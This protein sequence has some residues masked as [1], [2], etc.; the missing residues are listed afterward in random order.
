MAG[1]RDQLDERFDGETLDTDVWFPWYLPHWGSRAG[2]AATWSLDGEG[3]HLRIPADQPTWNPDLHDEPLRVSCLQTG[4]FAGPES[5]TR[6]GCPA[7]M[8]RGSKR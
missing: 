8:R 3:L 5:S 4:S 7:A 1:S 2:S 6:G